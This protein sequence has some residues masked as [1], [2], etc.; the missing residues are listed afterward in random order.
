MP[1]AHDCLN[2]GHWL[3]SFRDA[4]LPREVLRPSR[5]TGI[6]INRKR[7][8]NVQKNLG[9]VPNSLTAR[10]GGTELAVIVGGTKPLVKQEVAGTIRRAVA[11]GRLRGEDG[12]RVA[13][14]WRVQPRIQI[15]SRKQR[16]DGRATHCVGYPLPAT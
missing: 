16:R 3:R 7:T 13:V 15:L 6:G 14:V 8:Q 2:V 5:T 9:S 12:V 1:S 11:L 10:Y 4:H